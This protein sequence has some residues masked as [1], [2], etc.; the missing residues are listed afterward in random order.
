VDL[1]ARAQIAKQQAVEGLVVSVGLETS[2]YIINMPQ[3][4]Q[5]ARLYDGLAVEWE[6]EKLCD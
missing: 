1:R 4:Q 6:Y 2:K 5:Q 3:Q